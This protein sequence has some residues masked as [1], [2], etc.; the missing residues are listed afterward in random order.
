MQ[1][2]VRKDLQLTH[3][4]KEILFG[5]PINSMSNFTS[6]C[7]CGNF[8]DP[9]MHPNLDEIL[10]FFNKQRV[11]ISTNASLRST[12]WWNDLGKK[13][14][15]FVYFCIDGINETHE[16]YRRNTSYKKIIENAKSFIDSGGNAVWQFIIFKHN[17]HQ[18]EQ[19]KLLSK[20]LGFKE[21]HFIYS[22]RFDTSNVWKVFE[23]KQNIYNLEKASGY[24]TFREKMKTSEGKKYWSNLFL[25][26]Q[27]KNI[28]CKWSELKRIYIHSDGSVFP[29]CHIGN[30]LFGRPIE[31]SL[32]KKIIKD[33]QNI[34]LKY[35]SFVDIIEGPFYK[36]YFVQ[37]L[38]NSPHPVCIETCDPINGKFFFNQKNLIKY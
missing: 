7:L 30:I 22:E 26:S 38:K 20:E 23:N 27:K 9:L 33:W 35:N 34:N 32:Y 15:I 17:E 36:E 2:T 28:S 1:G 3:I 31:K 24:T 5:L 11:D 12:K 4:D 13:K 19:A 37:S 18:I 29:C 10:D 8:G 6:V 21:I 16:I 25:S 14:N